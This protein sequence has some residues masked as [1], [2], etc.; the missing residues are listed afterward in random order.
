MYAYIHIYRSYI[1]IYLNYIFKLHIYKCS[2]SFSIR[3]LQIKLLWNS[4]LSDA[5]WSTPR[6]QKIT[7][8]GERGMLI[9]CWWDCKLIQPVW[10]S[11][12]SFSKKLKRKLFIAQLQHF[13]E[14]TQR[15]SQATTVLAHPCLLVF[16]HYHKD[17]ISL[18]IHQ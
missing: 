6:I 1:H 11:M 7:N 10:K 17:E 2:A 4:I 5:K 9:H 16:F 13:M 12:W 15:I 8:A 18:N 14:C 3:K